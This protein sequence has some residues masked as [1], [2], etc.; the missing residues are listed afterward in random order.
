MVAA[1]RSDHMHSSRIVAF[2][3]FVVAL[4]IAGCGTANDEPAGLADPGFLPTGTYS[5]RI[6]AASCNVN[7]LFQ[8]TDRVALFR[9]AAGARAA[10]NIPLPT[11][12]GP[13]VDGS[14]FG[15]A[16]QD[17]DLTA[18]HHDLAIEDADG[19]GLVPTSID[20]TTLTASTLAISYREQARETCEVPECSV[21]YELDLVEAACPRDCNSTGATLHVDASG[22]M[23]WKCDCR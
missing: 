15:V 20:V 1:A 17:V 4:F 11:K 19:C 23:I 7:R 8:R 5:L 9:N 18:Q 16:R 2:T 6:V 10:A 14:V 13:G 12:L 21:E 3:S 22:S